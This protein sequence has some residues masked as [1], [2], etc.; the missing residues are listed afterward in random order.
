MLLR[1]VGPFVL[2]LSLLGVV[3]TDLITAG[4]LR[5]QARAADV[6]RAAAL[7]RAQLRP[8]VE[9]V[10][11][12]VQPLQDAVD[13][14]YR[15]GLD[16][17]QVVADVLGHSGADASLSDRSRDLTRL[18]VPASLAAQ[19]GGLTKALDAIM[20]GVAAL[21]SSSQ[22]PS[23]GEMSPSSA[24]LAAGVVAWSTAVG[25]VFRPLPM[26]SRAASGLRLATR[27][28]ASRPALIAT[29]DRL[30]G[31]SSDR[32]ATLPPISNAAQ[33]VQAGPRYAVLFRSTISALKSVPIPRSERD[34]VER[35]ISFY[36]A[37]ISGVA[38]GTD[39]IIAA[40]KNSNPLAARRGLATL[41]GGLVSS[42]AG[43]KGFGKYGATVCANFFF[44]PQKV[45]DGLGTAIGGSAA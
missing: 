23:G 37:G 24:L 40:I 14:F 20:K 38:T 44:V 11:D 28:P 8:V 39:N 1:R 32:V 6:A 12:V 30:C 43:S 3:G 19:A 16:V 21:E 41:R 29:F 2:A 27:E 4:H 42:V 36:Y 5:A 34:P 18:K 25:E 7:Y 35:Q 33:F 13:D 45:I 17:D 22:H 15:A 26:P 31:A 9:G 10:Y